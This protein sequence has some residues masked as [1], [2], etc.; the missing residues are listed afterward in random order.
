MS[1]V[2]VWGNCDRSNHFGKS[3]IEACPFCE[4]SELSDLRARARDIISIKHFIVGASSPD[5]AAQD[6]STYI[7]GR[8]GKEEG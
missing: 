6:V 4:L 7:L 8:E 5:E 1:L 3:H 2:T